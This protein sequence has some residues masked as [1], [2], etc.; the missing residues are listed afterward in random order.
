[1]NPAE[2][3]VL[4][5][6]VHPRA[7][8][9]YDQ[10][11]ADPSMR[12]AGITLLLKPDPSLESFLDELQD[13]SSAN[14]HRWLRPEQ[15][16]DRFGLS[17][18]DM[19]NIK[20]W[21]RSEGFQIDAAARG[22]HWIAFSGTAARASRAFHTEIHRY[23]VSGQMHYANSTEPSV[24]AALAGVVAGFEGLSDFRLQPHLV[25]RESL[26]EYDQ[27]PNHLLAPDDLATIYNV[28]PLYSAGIDGTGQSVAV[29]GT[30]AISLADLQAFRNKFGLAPND[31]QVVQVGA[32]PG[33]TG[34]LALL[35]A[36]LDLEWAGAIARNA[37][38][39]YVYSTSVTEAAQYA[40]DQ[41]LA[42]V[43]TMS[44]GG[45]E[46]D[47][48]VAFRGVAQ[49]ANA[50][51][52]TFLASSG[53]GGSATCDYRGVTPQASKGVTTDWPADF[54]EITGVGGTQFN[55]G[56]G[57][58]WST[59]NSA[60][61]GSALSY[62]PEAAWNDSTAANLVLAG[63]GGPSVL[64][65]K[66]IWQT[67]PGVPD[68]SERDVPD[69]ALAAAVYHDSYYVV[70]N[71]GGYFVGGTSAAS[72]TFA[73][74][75]ALLNQYL[76][77]KTSP[78]LTGL[79][80]I[81]PALYRL[82]QSTADVFHDVTSGDNKVPC[83]QSSPSCVDGLLGFQA[84]PGYDLA[85]GLGSV[86]AYHLVTEWNT[87]ASSSTT[88]TASPANYA[89]TDT[90][91][92]SATVTAAGGAGTPAGTVTFLTGDTALGT[93]SLSAS[94][95]SAI[96]SV[97]VSGILLA[98]GN[99][100][101]TALYNGDSTF[102]NSGAS[103]TVTLNLPAS[104]SL[105]VPFISPNPIYP[106][107]PG[108]IWV[109]TVR[110]TEKA[111]VS[112]TVQLFTINGGANR[113]DLLNGGVTPESGSLPL[114][115]NG[116]ISGA[117]FSSGLTPPVNQLFTFSGTDA[118]G[119]VWTRQVT[120]SFLAP[121]SRVLTPAMTLTS[122]SLN[123]QQNP[124][125]DPSC[126]WSQSL[127]LQEQSGYLVELTTF[128]AGGADVSNQIQQFFGTTRLAPFG[129]LSATLCWSSSAGP[130]AKQ[131]RISGA[132]TIG[133][134]VSA[135][136]I[137]ILQGPSA[138]PAAAAVSAPAITIPVPD[139]TQGATQTLDLNFTGGSPQWIASVS[140]ANA[141][142]AWLTV[143]P[144]S[145]AGSSTL[146][147]QASVDGLSKGVYRAVLSIAAQ[148]AI[149][150]VITVP[151]TFIVG[152]STVSSIG[153]IANNLSYSTAI[154]PGEQ[155]A[156]F[157][158]QLAPST[159][160]ASFM[161]GALPLTLAGVSATVN[162]IAAPLYYVSPN[163]LDIQIPYEAGIGPSVLAIDNNGQ[164]ASFSFPMVVSAPGMLTFLL[165]P[166]FHMTAS[167]QPGDVLIT[168]IT[169]EGDTTPFIATGA[170]P[171]SGTPVAKLPQP[172]LPVT[173]TVGGVPA[174]VLFV[175]IIPGVAGEMQLNFQVPAAASGPQPVVVTVGNSSSP[176]VIL[177]VT[178]AP[179][180]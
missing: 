165:D 25:N 28:S 2:T 16:A 18:A 19:A 155:V 73:G 3:V 93:A 114:P 20:S 74:M 85:T 118:D 108:P 55:E 130:G 91:Q 172:L 31:P 120:V 87:G 156:V 98:G 60:A 86:D 29:V 125:A 179:A 8:S 154:A 149:P 47:N 115:A 79:G 92:L 94:S 37:N 43:L 62:I 173:V 124:Q 1:M 138:S 80:N 112:T 127:T 105:A 90:V 24:P 89:L 103:A 53:D 49:Q 166:S 169:G 131:Y 117:I 170:T 140:P 23:L 66:P 70:S 10:G 137:A 168:Y 159:K 113:L 177:N 5:G 100:T 22:R 152:A 135:S 54:P 81:N 145:G 139:A 67:G 151:V 153:G 6:H 64:F 65:P 13:R 142:G 36:D 15:F 48:S 129:M 174:T 32:D 40:I 122:A 96:A 59:T 63:G 160:V 77:S 164:I 176:P 58:Y 82:A 95:G 11:P 39:I 147:L 26:P 51:G 27:G 126:Q 99:G 148:D 33:N 76:A 41:N 71:G 144:S 119:R 157:G 7:L 42:P 34:G 121:D 136:L 30:T 83:V 134:T 17:D 132:S 104:G 133:S 88:L 161:N 158:T 123:P 69:L 57:T 72:P 52:I 56:T 61:D 163:Q 45:C 21:L 44:Y 109:Y 141:A 4:K 75:L 146:N 101:A 162:G 46:L 68:D 35:E 167:A 171:V 180:Q 178:A 84:G 111:G 110:L 102:N 12:L 14:F 107:S 175:G 143:S 116:Q 128:T 38:L 50:Q 97:Q 150:Q 9:Q 106:Q 78:A